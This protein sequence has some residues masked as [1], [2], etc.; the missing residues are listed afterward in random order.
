MAEK[1]AEIPRNSSS[2]PRKGRGKGKNSSP[3]LVLGLV[4]ILPKVSSSTSS[5]PHDPSRTS[6]PFP[7]LRWFV[8]FLVIDLEIFNASSKGTDFD[9]Y[10]WMAWSVHN[11]VRTSVSL[12]EAFWILFSYIHMGST[13]SKVIGM[14][15]S[16]FFAW[17]EVG[18]MASS[19]LGS[20][21][22]AKPLRSPQPRNEG[23]AIIW[24]RWPQEAIPGYQSMKEH[25]TAGLTSGLNLR[26]CLFLLWSPSASGWPTPWKACIVSSLKSIGTIVACKTLTWNK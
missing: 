4:N 3:R 26:I 12:Q 21:W 2:R 9:F 14:F 17:F 7:Q 8:I 16:F 5:S 15:S 20:K 1:K 24:G 6:G 11:F 18:M 23:I 13:V 25:V 10:C 19:A 22:L